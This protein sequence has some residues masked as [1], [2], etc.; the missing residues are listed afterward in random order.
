MAVRHYPCSAAPP[1]RAYCISPYKSGTT[2]IAGLFKTPSNRVAHEPMH[3]T[4]LKNIHDITFL[5]RRARYL[6]LDLESSGFFADKLHILRMFSPSAPVLFLSR[7]PELWIGS[8]INY[9][10]RLNS[11]V[12]FNY[13][14]RLY[15][16]PICQCPIDQFFNLEF[17]SQQ[18]VIHALL[19]YWL[20]V[21]ERAVS[22]PFSL[23][24]DLENLDNQISEVADFIHLQP[25]A[26]G[27]WKREGVDKKRLVV[28]DYVKVCDYNERLAKFGYEL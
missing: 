16:D 8:V 7:H 21:Y 11:S 5:T 10:A 27:A 24:V 13:T 2:Y 18:H 12:N 23:V 9:F 4:T 6:S 15:F 25:N 14:A 22:D 17:V 1:T 19:K 26:K 20:S 28:K 3:Y